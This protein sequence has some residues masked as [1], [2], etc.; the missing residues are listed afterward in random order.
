M[1]IR[2]VALLMIVQIHVLA[3]RNHFIA[4]QSEN[5]QPFY[6]RIETIIFN[7]TATGHLIIPRLTDSTYIIAIGFSKKIVAEEKFS[8]TITKDIGFILKITKDKGLILSNSQT[9]Q[10]IMPV[11]QHEQDFTFKDSSRTISKKDDGFAKLM[12]Q[13]VNDSAV[14]E[15][16]Y[17]TDEPKK[18]EP[19]KEIVKNETPAKP[20][21]KIDSTI[22]IDLTKKKNE[23]SLRKK[24]AVI[25]TPEKKGKV[26]QP[27]IQKSIVKKLSE[28]KT[29]SAIE[30]VYEDFVSEG[31]KDT[32]HIIIPLDSNFA[33]NKQVALANINKENIKKD[34][35]TLSETKSEIKT[36]SPL[37]R[38]I[39][40]NNNCKN[41]AT[42]YDVDKL[43]VKMLAIED[44]DDK[45]STA[46]KIFK[47]KCFSTNQIS[48]LSEVFSTDAGKYKLFDAAYS[49]VSDVNN[50]TRL[51]NLM[52]DEYYITRFK[53]MI[54]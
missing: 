15:N 1:K 42:D 8:I 3:Q 48:A 4:I 41:T 14:M 24:V 37:F 20:I 7:S 33:I 5:K 50:F 46:K 47:T 6:A 27:K 23:D 54:K 18:E 12:S 25:K 32:I 40:I 17:V 21:I 36:D 45:I 34:T 31:T 9:A 28:Q 38:Q 22:A 49:Y 43:R 10:I 39:A 26:L 35:T 2:I 53:A 13:V 29:D 30:L 52:K 19:K 11:K 51:Q 16:M 44:E